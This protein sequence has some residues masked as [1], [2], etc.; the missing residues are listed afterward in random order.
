MKNFC[1]IIYIL[2]GLGVLATYTH[3]LYTNHENSSL[4]WG[5]IPESIRV[6]YVVGMI[7]AAIGYLFSSYYIF[8]VN[9]NNYIYFS[10]AYILI[11]VPSVFW[12]PLTFKYIYN[13]QD[14]YWFLIKLALFLVA[15]GSF[16]CVIFLIY[17]KPKNLNLSYILGLTGSVLFFL[18][19]FILD[20]ILWPYFFKNR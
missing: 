3:G 14:F 9:S 11:L 4:L 15:F 1:L 10:L 13:Q 8:F 18:H 17:F 7:L 6:W 12:M 20:S 19:T 5:G 2:G 16:L